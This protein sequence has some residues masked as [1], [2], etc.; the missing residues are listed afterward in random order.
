MHPEVAA[1]IVLAVDLAHPN[2][3]LLV[4]NALN[5]LLAMRSMM[6]ANQMMYFLELVM[7]RARVATDPVF[8]IVWVDPNLSTFLSVAMKANKSAANTGPTVKMV[9]IA[10]FSILLVSARKSML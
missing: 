1:V 2:A 10:H 6:L 4:M 9:T 3:V 5:A 7:Q 8:L